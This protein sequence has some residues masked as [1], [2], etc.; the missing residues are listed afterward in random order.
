[1][2]QVHQL[3]V[4]LFLALIGCAVQSEKEQPESTVNTEIPIKTPIDKKVR[5]L[6]NSDKT[7]KLELSQEHL[8]GD[9][10]THFDLRIIRLTNEEVILDTV[11]RG[12]DVRWH[13]V[14]SIA[15]VPYVGMVQK[16]S[17]TNPSIEANQPK[18][19]TIKN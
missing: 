2:R 9:P 1:M 17:A 15:L 16:E 14:T 13:G 5:I 10:A 19:I 3:F 6:Y 8:P 18:I 7:F 4:I 11:F 12:S